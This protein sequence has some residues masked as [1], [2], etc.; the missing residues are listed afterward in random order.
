M[1]WL[2]RAFGREQVGRFF[3]QEPIADGETVRDVFE[4][5]AGRYERFDEYVYDTGAG[6]VRGQVNVVIN[7]RLLVL[8]QGLDTVLS[9]GDVV[10]LVSCVRRGWALHRTQ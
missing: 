4:R 10:V 1:S 2:A 6:H 5:L 8:R 3:I 7:D 9:E